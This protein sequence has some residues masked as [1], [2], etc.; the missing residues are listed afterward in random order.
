MLSFFIDIVFYGIVPENTFAYFI[1]YNYGYKSIE[2][3][4]SFWI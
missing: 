4:I 1:L 2:P 3:I